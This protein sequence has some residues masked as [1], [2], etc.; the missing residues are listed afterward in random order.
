MR[1][2]RHVQPIRYSSLTLGRVEH[3]IT[4]TVGFLPLNISRT[5]PDQSQQ[6]TQNIRNF[7]A[8]C[9][10]SVSFGKDM[11][12]LPKGFVFL[13]HTQQT[14]SRHFCFKVAGGMLDHLYQL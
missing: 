8:L 7:R 13:G 12:L 10:P 9:L 5:N 14:I 4:I 6:C 2:D 11:F 1:T 3:L